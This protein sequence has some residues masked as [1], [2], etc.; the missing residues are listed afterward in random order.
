M[1]A[2]CVPERTGASS[3][4]KRV[5]DTANQVKRLHAIWMDGGYRVLS[6]GAR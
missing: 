3:V 5:H 2:A 1:S 6:L 4:L